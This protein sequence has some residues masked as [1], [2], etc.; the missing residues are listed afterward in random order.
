MLRTSLYRLA[1]L[2]LPVPWQ[3]KMASGSLNWPSRVSFHASAGPLFAEHLP[4]NNTLALLAA[5]PQRQAAI[6]RG[7][8][9]KLGHLDRVVVVLLPPCHDERARTCP[10]RVGFFV[11]VRE[12][13]QESIDASH[14]KNPADRLGPALEHA[15]R[16]APAGGPSA[17]RRGRCQRMQLTE[18]ACSVGGAA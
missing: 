5:V 2:S 17:S 4:E 14:L 3:F 6:D 11:E 1:P 12:V 8:G 18:A 15:Q 7:N 10:F 9:V 13:P 16:F